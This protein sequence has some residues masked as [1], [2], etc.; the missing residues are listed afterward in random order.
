[1]TQGE[2]QTTQANP[3][4]DNPALHTQVGGNILFSYPNPQ[5]KHSVSDKQVAQGVTHLIHSVPLWKYPSTQAEQFPG[6][7][8]QVLHPVGQGTHNSPDR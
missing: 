6:L 5:L 8:T 2:V 3:L 1:M 7:L 4:S